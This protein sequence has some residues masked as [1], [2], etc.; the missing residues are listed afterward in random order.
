MRTE[1]LLHS[2]PVEDMKIDFRII[3]KVLQLSLPS[4]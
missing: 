4:L 1:S 3:L 2:A